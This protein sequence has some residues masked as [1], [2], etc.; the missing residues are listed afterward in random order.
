LPQAT[1][2]PPITTVATTIGVGLLDQA[3][4]RISMLGIM[5]TQCRTQT[6]TAVCTSIV[7]MLLTTR[8]LKLGGMR[9][10][11]V[12]AA[13]LAMRLCSVVQVFSKIQA[14]YRTCIFIRLGATD[15]VATKVG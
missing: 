7:P 8:T 13:T 5:F 10:V 9:Q 15:Q 14:P 12:T 3:T 4:A 11:T 6:T 1:N 2:L